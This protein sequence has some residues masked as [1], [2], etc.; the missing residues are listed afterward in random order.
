[1]KIHVATD[2]A[3]LELKNSIREYLIDKG[4]DV[5]DHGAHEYDALDDYPDFIF[6]CAQAVAA[7]PESRGIILGGSGQG[8]AMAA[9]RIKGV[10]AAVF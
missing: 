5:T 3:G 9:N 7:D 2:H 4:H 10:R 1:M 6:P 8:E